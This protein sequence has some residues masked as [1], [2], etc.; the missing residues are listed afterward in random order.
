MCALVATYIDAIAA[1]RMVFF[2][3]HLTYLRIDKMEF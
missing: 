3:I 1:G 2:T